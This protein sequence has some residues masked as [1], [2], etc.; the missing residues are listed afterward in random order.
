LALSDIRTALESAKDFGSKPVVDPSR[1][2]TAP[3]A[4]S[5]TR[6]QAAW[7]VTGFFGREDVVLERHRG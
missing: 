5:R 1:H 6:S 7:N 2:W 3:L 4:S